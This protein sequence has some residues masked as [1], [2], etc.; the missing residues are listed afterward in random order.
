MKRQVPHVRRETH[1]RQGAA[2]KNVHVILA[3]SVS[4]V[5]KVAAAMGWLGWR[6]LS[7]DKALQQQQTRNRLE[8]GADLLLTGFLRRMTETEA[9]LS[10]IGL[11]LPATARLERSALAKS[12]SISS[13]WT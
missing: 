3:T 7:E 9:W 8:Q 11:S 10:Q 4:L 5:L 1:A 2:L 12:N 6:L 13:C